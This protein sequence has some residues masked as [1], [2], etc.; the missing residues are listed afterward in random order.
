[1]VFK[2]RRKRKNSFFRRA[3]RSTF[4]IIILT[5]FVFGIS[6]FV[7]ELSSLA[8]DSNKVGR[9]AAPLLAQLGLPQEDAGQV[10]GEFVERFSQTGL[11]KNDVSSLDSTSNNATNDAN[12]G[13]KEFSTAS[14][15]SIKDSSKKLFSIALFAESEDDIDNLQLA[16]D[17]AISLDVDYIVHLG[18]LTQWGDVE[19]LTTIK[20]VL[21]ESGI[22]WYAVPGDL[23]LGQSVGTSNFLSVFNTNYTMLTLKDINILVLDNSANYT[24][25]DEE[26]FTWFLNNIKKAD[27]VM[28][29][30]PLYHPTNPKVMGI[31]DGETQEDVYNQKNILLSEIRKYDI[32]AIF[33]ADQH[34]AS[35]S[36]DEEKENLFHYVV[37][38]LAKRRN[39]QTPRFSVLT[40]FEDGAYDVSEIIL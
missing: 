33:A 23:D 11:V 3:F 1:M 6:L 10:A 18:D 21:S 37:G 17:K 7:K 31:V 27:F 20:K 4:A 40:V 5:A 13:N 12:E 15:K 2:R 29:S 9:L 8:Q 14:N 35:K 19:S 22:S 16:I 25:L 28:F 38:A 26:R 36:A 24:P 34:M 39:L 32:K 30:Q